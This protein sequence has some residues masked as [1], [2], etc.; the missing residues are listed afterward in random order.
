MKEFSGDNKT[1]VTH[2][3]QDFR[4]VILVKSPQHNES[5]HKNIKA[6]INTES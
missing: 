3:R 2:V 1:A 5:Q 6:K 4:E